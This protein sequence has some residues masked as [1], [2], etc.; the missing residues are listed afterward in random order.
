MKLKIYIQSLSVNERV[1]F[2]E[3]CETTLKHL[4][5]VAYGYKIAGENLCINIERESKGAVRCE[6]LRTDVD[7]GFLRGTSKQAQT[8][9]KDAA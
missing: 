3:N 2:A 7:W 4:R 5:N 8:N 1:V 9:S 6:E